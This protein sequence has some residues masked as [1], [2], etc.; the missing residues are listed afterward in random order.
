MN[1]FT[2]PS[3]VENNLSASESAEIIADHFA[4]ISQVYDPI[5]V[6]NFPPNIREALSQPNLSVVPKLEDYEVYTKICK[7]KKPNSTVLGDLPKKVVQ[8]FSCELTSPLTVIYKSILKTFQYPRQ[9]VIEYQLPLP[10]SYPPA[11]EDELRKNI[12]LQQGV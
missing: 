1:T 8:E 7:A 5:N 3:H 6:D 10:K 4:A 11:S 12:L 2:L 9:W